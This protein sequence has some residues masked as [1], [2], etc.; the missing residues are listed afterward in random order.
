MRPMMDQPV[1]TTAP[2]KESTLGLRVE[3]AKR[4]MWATWLL[5]ALLCTNC[6]RGIFKSNY[7][8][9]PRY[10]R[11]WTYLLDMENVT[12]FFAYGNRTSDPRRGGKEEHRGQ[13]PLRPLRCVAPAEFFGDDRHPCVSMET[14]YEALE[15][16]RK[17]GEGDSTR[18]LK[19]HRLWERS[20]LVPVQALKH[21]L[22]QNLSKPGSVFVT[23]ISNS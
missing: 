18:L 23:P 14:L 21:T 20:W 2:D 19:L 22:R 13:L 8:F 11:D 12:A 1:F 5:A 3:L 7:I 16:S 17:T 10:T 15:L 9:E 4:Y 6:Y